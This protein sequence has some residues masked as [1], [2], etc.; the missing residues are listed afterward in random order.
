M[1]LF[2]YSRVF[3]PVCVCVFQSVQTVIFLSAQALLMVTCLR[4]QP[5]RRRYPTNIL[6]DWPKRTYKV[7]H[8]NPSIPKTYCA[9]LNCSSHHE[10]SKI[11]KIS[12]WRKAPPLGGCRLFEIP[13]QI[14]NCT[15]TALGYIHFLCPSFPARTGLSKML[16]LQARQRKG[17]ER[18]PS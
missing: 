5:K 15:K 16:L 8:I 9:R 7:L 11:S 14:V 1:V 10:S 3:T 12:F 4:G 17:R 6:R 2:T 13:S 18:T